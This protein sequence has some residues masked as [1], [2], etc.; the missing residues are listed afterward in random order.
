MT[1][2]GSR[3]FLKEAHTLIQQVSNR[4]LLFIR[5][6]MVH[7]QAWVS[8]TVD[9]VTFIIFSYG[10]EEYIGIRH[11]ERQTLYLSQSITPSSASNPTH[12]KLQ[13]AIFIA[14]FNDAVNRTQSSKTSGRHRV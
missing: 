8:A 6:L 11:R 3:S 7:S 10:N 9:D 12:F 4:D 13:I 5:L 2:I 1:V 14:S